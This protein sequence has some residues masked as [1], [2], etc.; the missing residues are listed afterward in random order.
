M[1]LKE[2]FAETF[3]PFALSALLLEKTLETS[4]PD[5]MSSAL[6]WFIILCV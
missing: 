6:S 1:A 3:R 5:E 2:N 4:K